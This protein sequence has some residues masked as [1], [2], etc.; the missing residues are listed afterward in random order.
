[1]YEVIKKK[2]KKK[3]EKSVTID[4]AK[5]ISHTSKPQFLQ[6][7]NLGNIKYENM[8]KR[9]GVFMK[10]K[11]TKSV[12]IYLQKVRTKECFNVIHNFRETRNET[13]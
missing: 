4:C 8:V 9:Q 2:R 12:N 3:K 1:M 5:F 6:N 10:F 7:L 11:T 13:K